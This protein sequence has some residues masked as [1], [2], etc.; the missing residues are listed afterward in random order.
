MTSNLA[1]P[2]VLTVSE[3]DPTGAS[4]VQADLKTLA[5][6]GV[7][8]TSA[9]T[10]VV[11][12]SADRVVAVWDLPAELTAL[13]IDTALDGMGA[14]AVKTGMLASRDTVEA[15]A[16]KIRQHGI[17]S[18]VL[19]PVLAK[20]GGDVDDGV[21]ESIRTE[22]VPLARVVTPN[23]PEAGLLTGREIETLDDAKTAAAA[24][25]EMGAACAVVTGGQ[26]AGPATD[27]LYDGQDLR[28]FTS[29]R[30]ESADVRGAGAAFSAAL[31]AGLA[32]GLDVRDAAS[33]TKKYVTA[34]LR[35]ALRIG[36]L[37]VVD[38][39]H[40]KAARG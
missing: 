30:A 12:R 11:A 2:T 20:A 10:A 28:M 34:A 31:A 29:Q 35:R 16:G 7:Y 32:N 26:F 25:V 1:P 38:H 9:V 3:S 14:G 37:G 36:A 19:D 18:L 33:Q 13:Q 24:I 21:V 5:A 40:E 15:V 4:G 27:V 8:G 23:A 39:L 6:F 22:L 17:D